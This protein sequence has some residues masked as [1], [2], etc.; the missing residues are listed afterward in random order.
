[1]KKSLTITL[2]AIV[3]VFFL[4]RGTRTALCYDW[5]HHRELPWAGGVYFDREPVVYGGVRVANEQYEDVLNMGPGQGIDQLFR[6]L[7]RVLGSVLAIGDMVLS[8]IADTL[9]LPYTVPR[10]AYLNRKALEIE[11][12]NSE[13]MEQRKQA[14]GRTAGA[15]QHSALFEGWWRASTFVTPITSVRKETSS[16]VRAASASALARYCG[17]S[18]HS[19]G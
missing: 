18:A 5:R 8:S 11:R 2:V 13:R 6:P 4:A 1:M 16:C 3:A 14:F 12:A 7:G 19:A 17:S 10:Q 15:G 9:A